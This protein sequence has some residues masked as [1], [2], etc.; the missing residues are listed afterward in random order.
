MNYSLRAVDKSQRRGGTIGSGIVGMPE[1]REEVHLSLWLYPTLSPWT[2]ETALEGWDRARS[3]WRGDLT[4]GLEVT[5][6]GFGAR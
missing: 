3:S 5:G 1:A 4:V 2:K 6:T